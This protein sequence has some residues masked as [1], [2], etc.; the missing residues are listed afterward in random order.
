MHS[1]ALA[2]AL[3]FECKLSQKQVIG[4]WVPKTE[5]GSSDLFRGESK[6]ISGIEW[7]DVDQ[8]LILT[9]GGGIKIDLKRA[10]MVMEELSRVGRPL[11]QSG[12]VIVNEVTGLPFEGY[13]FRREWRAT[14]D[15]AGIPKT[16]QNMHSH[17]RSSTMPSGPPELPARPPSTRQRFS[18]WREPGA[19][20][21]A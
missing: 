19:K 20:R 9:V 5:P 6:W 16:V 3:Q 10:A 11:P 17:R 2:Q 7:S 4:E 18:L 21:S 15:A 13:Q 12:P 8:D 1:I 14:A